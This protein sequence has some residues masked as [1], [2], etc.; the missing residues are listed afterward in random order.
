MAITGNS[1]DKKVVAGKVIYTGLAKVK[2]IGINP[3][4][5]EAE[6][7]GLEFKN[8]PKYVEDV[9]SKLKEG[10]KVKRLRLDF[11]LAS[12]EEDITLSKATKLTFFITNEKRK[13]K[14]G[15]YLF[16]DK[17]GKTAWGETK[18]DAGK[19]D[20]IDE[21]SIRFA[22]NGED[23]LYA[24]IQAWLNIKPSDECQLENIEKLFEGNVKELRELPR[25]FENSVE[26]LLTVRQTDNGEFQ[27]VYN[28][29]FGRAANNNL[30]YWATYLKKQAESGYAVEGYQESLELQEYKGELDVPKP[31]AD[32][33][34]PFLT[35]GSED[36]TDA[37]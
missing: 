22:R 27:N 29:K 21:E 14:Q 18:E 35:S 36:E 2:I 12:A 15:K 8:P 4:Q 10:E 19:R 11:Y 9:D 24:F 20:W 25:A 3:S 16:L 7:I 23:D 6:S 1:S 13:S 17:F 5:E 37:F 26:V 34:D 33:E 32:A 28:K 30:S 31:D